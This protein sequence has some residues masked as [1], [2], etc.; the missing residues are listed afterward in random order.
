M[1]VN[2]QLSM[3][4]FNQSLEMMRNACIPKT[5]A[6]VGKCYQINLQLDYFFFFF[7]KF[8]LQIMELSN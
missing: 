4:Q 7:F 1:L 3:K 8:L 6:A 5:G 2:E